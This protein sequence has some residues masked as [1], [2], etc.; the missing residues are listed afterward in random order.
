MRPVLSLEASVVGI[1]ESKSSF[2][3][4]QLPI[5]PIVTFIQ[6]RNLEFGGCRPYVMIRST[7]LEVR[8]VKCHSV[9]RSTELAQVLQYEIIHRSSP[10]ASA[11]QATNSRRLRPAR[12][13]GKTAF[14]RNYPITFQSATSPGDGV[15]SPRSTRPTSSVS[16]ALTG[17]ATPI[18][19]PSLAIIP[20]R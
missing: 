14:P 8:Q 3:T 7:S 6:M 15:N 2:Q 12:R 10:I 19:A 13:L 4:I 9:H 17:A 18:F 20:F 5:K 1:P 16:R 11:L